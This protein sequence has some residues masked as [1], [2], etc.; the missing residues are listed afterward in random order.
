[1]DM[2]LT[3]H[4]LRA[5]RPCASGFRWFVRNQHCGNDYQRVLDALVNDGRV[6]DARWLMGQFGATDQV[7]EVDHLEARAVVF[8]GSVIVR[9][10]VRVP[11]LLVVGGSLRAGAGVHV[12]T[13]EVGEDLRC[14]GAVFAT[15]D[16][17]LGGRLRA[18]WSVQVQG[19]L[20][21]DELRVGWGL[22]CGGPVSVKG[23]ATIGEALTASS[24]WQCGKGLRVGGSIE[25]AGPLTVGHGIVT[26]G[27]IEGGS[28]VEAGWGMRAGGDIRAAGSIRAGETLAAEGDIQ[29]GAGYGIYAGLNVQ[30][31][32]WAHSAWVKAARKPQALVSG[33]WDGD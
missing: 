25:V 32:A 4:F 11:E 16:V 30:M 21:A 15:G 20:Q 7:L 23:A 17:R 14:E 33:H 2:A 29:A 19:Q 12:G 8:A 13:L 5:K 18:A 31:E 6:D 22:D 3:Q 27:S 9:G 1:M 26:L 28:H 24:G 10:E